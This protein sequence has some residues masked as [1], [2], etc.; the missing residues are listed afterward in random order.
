MRRCPV[1]SFS[2]RFPNTSDHPRRIFSRAPKMLHTANEEPYAGF[3][4][5]CL[6]VEAVMWKLKYDRIELHLLVDVDV[7][8]KADWVVCGNHAVKMFERASFAWLPQPTSDGIR[9]FTPDDDK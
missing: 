9:L 6:L 8:G 1:L 3:G 4:P 5:G 7:S 2:L